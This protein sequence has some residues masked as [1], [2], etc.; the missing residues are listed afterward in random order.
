M[1]ALQQFHGAI[2]LVLLC[3]LLFAEEAGV[4]LLVVSGD[5]ILVSAGLLI[6]TGG[7]DPR[8]F[9]P[10]A[11]LASV[12]GALVGYTWSRRLGEPALRS[13]AERLGAQ[14]QLNRVLAKVRG[15]SPVQIAVARLLPG[16]R[17]YTT[18]AAG[19]A[20]VDR[21]TFL[22]GVS[23]ATVIW[24]LIFTALGAV[25]GIP[26]ERALGQFERFALQG[27]IL[28]LVGVGGYLVLRRIPARAAI[29]TARIPASVRLPLALLLDAGIVAAIAAGLL[30]IGRRAIGTTANPW[31]DV[32]IIVAL[33]ALVFLAV[34]LHRAGGTA[35][36][37]LRPES[38][39]ERRPS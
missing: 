2:A 32:A 21:T 13:V 24:V 16:L 28:M 39:A 19:A 7:L 29:V 35:G 25:I 8:V 5:L 9:V 36:A 12:L 17:V 34:R 6:A 37:S 18:L 11:V 1:S 3:G 10:L 31:I 38:E 23:P 22:A 26:A 14:E 27:A 4:P 20:G 30:T 15:A 33:V